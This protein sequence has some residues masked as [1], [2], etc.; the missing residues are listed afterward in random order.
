MSTNS[1]DQEIDLGQVFSKIGKF[2]KKIVDSTFD[3][4]LFVRKNII[5]L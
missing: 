3:A 2:F 5:I 4:V 1:Q